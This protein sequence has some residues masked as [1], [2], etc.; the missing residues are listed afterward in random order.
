M[1]CDG[2]VRLGRSV[3]DYAVDLRRYTH[4]VAITNRRLRALDPQARTLIFTCKD[5]TDANRIKAMTLTGVEF[6]CRFCL[7]LLPPGFV[8][9][10]H[11]GLLGNNRRHQRRPPKPRPRVSTETQRTA[12]V[13]A[14]RCTARPR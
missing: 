10:R 11:Y 3:A 1:L 7:H 9:I 8:K 2:D 14:V 13:A 4:R 6:L 12:S 5:Y